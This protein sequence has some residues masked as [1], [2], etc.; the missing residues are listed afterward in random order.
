MAMIAYKCP[1]IQVVVVDINQ[2]RT[3]LAARAE[4]PLMSCSPVL[5]VLREVPLPSNLA[6][7]VPRVPASQG[8]CASNC[9]TSPLCKYE[10]LRL[11]VAPLGALF[12]R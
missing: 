7:I 6:P 11:P 3:T 1:E 9:W 2:V 10:R 4:G 8:L 12:S 5:T